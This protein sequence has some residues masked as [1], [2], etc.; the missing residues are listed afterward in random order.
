LAINEE[1]FSHF[2]MYS[3]YGLLSHGNL[4]PTH[5]AGIWIKRE[6]SKSKWLNRGMP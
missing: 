1:S 5:S 6:W 4:I 2:F 3:K